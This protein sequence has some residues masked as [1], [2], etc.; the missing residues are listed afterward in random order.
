MKGNKVEVGIMGRRVDGHSRRL[1][2]VIGFLVLLT[3]AVPLQAFNVGDISFYVTNDFLYQY[4]QLT[5]N[6]KENQFY[7]SL[8]LF[9]NY[10]KW[11]VG[12]T[13]RGNNFF[14]QSPNMTLEDPQLDVFR[15]YVQ[16][17]SKHLKI[18]VGDFYSLLGRGMVLSV[19]KNEDILRERT[20]LGGDVRYNRGRLDLRVL[21]GRVKDETENQEWTVAGGEINLE[22]V[23]HHRIGFHFSYIDDIDTRRQ[24]GKRLTTSISLKGSQLFKNISYYTEVALLDYQDT[25][26][27]VFTDNGYGIYSNVT[28]SKSHVTCF[29]EFK[30]YK[31]F[32]NEMNNP[33][34]ADREDEIASIRDTT[35]LR[36]YFQY[37]FFEPDIT[38]FFNAA[39]YEEHGD[40]GNHFYGGVNIEDLMDRLNLSLSYGVRDIHYRIK[41]WDG[42][43]I[44]QFTDRW[45][46]EIIFKDKHY[47]DGSFIFKEID[48]N[49]QV[50]YSPFISV[51]FLHQ[52]SHNRIANLNYFFSGGIK[53][54]LPGGT[55]VELSGG[56]IRGGQICSG[57]QCFVA[58]PF[59]GVKCFIL[60]T[61]K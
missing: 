52:Y 14:K 28:Y 49:F 31:D 55:V 17:S 25:D 60:H 41:R 33:P 15:K 53:V 16:Y 20:I 35:G 27:L 13:L 24:L 5:Y 29:L 40:T 57:G 30:R 18:T 19:L 56:T 11:S 6:N 34:A 23:K 43:L 12:L 37:A 42:H 26:A 44:Y 47:R 50:S 54:Y 9:A 3:V 7:E 61:F 22:Y 59:K 10:K 46:S 51:F 38:L 36:F 32:N 2:F 45:S 21:G 1:Y 48:Y 58:P 8:T 4:N 39:R